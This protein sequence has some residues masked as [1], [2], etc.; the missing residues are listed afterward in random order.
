MNKQ[1]LT[2]MMVVKT[3][4]RKMD[5]VYNEIRPAI[6]F[7]EITDFLDKNPWVAKE[8]K[9]ASGLISVIGYKSISEKLILSLK[10]KPYF[11]PLSHLKEFIES[12]DIS[13]R[14]LEKAI[15]RAKKAIEL[16]SFGEEWVVH[17][18]IWLEI[19]E[20]ITT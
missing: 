10:K 7:Q 8:D 18:Q 16:E 2:E 1:Q 9:Y 15:K 12:E 5:Y 4:F 13:I 20:S 11:K 17:H 14:G 3:E 19:L 6:S